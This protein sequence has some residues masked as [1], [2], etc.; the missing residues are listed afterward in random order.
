[1]E[2]QQIDSTNDLKFMIIKLNDYSNLINDGVKNTR[3][4]I[5]NS[6][7]IYNIVVRIFYT[8]IKVMPDFQ[9]QIHSFA[10]S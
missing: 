1:M 5:N 3:V 6:S 7:Y 2:F 4:D 8:S 10:L 9:S